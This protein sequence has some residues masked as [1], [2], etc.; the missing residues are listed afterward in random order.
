MDISYFKTKNGDAI[1]FGDI[2][3]TATTWKAF[4]AENQAILHDSA[5]DG[6]DVNPLLTLCPIH[7]MYID[8][9]GALCFELLTHL[10]GV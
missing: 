5:K 8:T 1:R 6:G 7:W 2:N 10:E 9:N 3:F 4:D